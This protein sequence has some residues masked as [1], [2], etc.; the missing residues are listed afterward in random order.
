MGEFLY[1]LCWINFVVSIGV[2]VEKI[3]IGTIR[4][5]LKVDLG[6]SIEGGRGSLFLLG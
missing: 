5:S 4:S 2:F 1:G 3:G 6:G